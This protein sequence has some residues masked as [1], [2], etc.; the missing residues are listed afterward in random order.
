IFAQTSND[1]IGN[2]VLTNF[3]LLTGT[4]NSKIFVDGAV[5]TKDNS[6]IKEDGEMILTGNFYQAANTPAFAI[7]ANNGL[8]TST[9]KVTFRKNYAERKGISRIRQITFGPDAAS[10]DRGIQYIAFPNIF[11]ETGDTL[12]V[13]PT[14]GIDARGIT[15][16]GVLLL[17]SDSI[18]GGVWDASLRLP[19]ATGNS[20]STDDYAQDIVRAGKVAIER[21][22]L[23]YRNNSSN[24]LFPFATPYTNQRSGYFAG[25]WVRNPILDNN[26]YA[27]F[28]LANAMDGSGSIFPEYYLTDAEE[29]FLVG[30]PY[31]IKPR[32]RTFRYGLDGNFELKL[33]DVNLDHD[34][35]MFLFDGTP[36]CMP[37]LAEQIVTN[38]TIFNRTWISSNSLSNKYMPV[39]NSYSAPLSVDSINKRIVSS[40]VGIGP[41]IYVLLAGQTSYKSFKID[42]T[43]RASQS[44]FYTDYIPSQSVFMLIRQGNAASSSL[45]IGRD[46]VVHAARS[47]NMR[48]ADRGLAPAR[49]GVARSSV[50]RSNLLKFQVNTDESDHIFDV[51]AVFVREDAQAGADVYDMSKMASSEV[52][53]FSLYMTDITSGAKQLQTGVPLET[54]SVRMGFK[55]TSL[56]GNYVLTASNVESMTTDAVILEDTKENVFQDLRVNDTY[57]FSSLAED[58]VNRFVVHFKPVNTAEETTYT[59]LATMNNINIYAFNNTIFINNLDENDMNT[60]VGIFDVAGKQAGKFTVNGYPQMTYNAQNLVQGTY[61]VRKLDGRQA[62]AKFIVK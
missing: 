36:Y 55:P 2:V 18:N 24:A 51:A 12:V 49:S 15:G 26:G 28:P 57:N 48:D 42:P 14:M 59:D 31:L 53:L 54:K 62:V 27:M 56:G 41:D 38:E 40:S 47:N 39:G 23:T 16:K 21:Y 1:T 34:L 50:D 29:T 5:K 58:A 61:I 43:T 4:S 20:T 60:S 45:S 30:Q 52:D 7:D 8:G 10:P 9:G 19:V 25:N 35:D 46:C 11:I 44:A 33:T 6:A 37:Y 32:I 13:T 3:G 17:A 22:M